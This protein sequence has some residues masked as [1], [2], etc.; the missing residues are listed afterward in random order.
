MN[1]YLGVF[2]LLV[3]GVLAG[4]QSGEKKEPADQEKPVA[5]V[6]KHRALNPIAP[7]GVFI[8]DPEVRQ[9]I[10]IFRFG[11]LERRAVLFCY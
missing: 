7:P 6:S 3:M 1:N 11:E 5:S 2:G 10:V 9:C 4:C 8:A